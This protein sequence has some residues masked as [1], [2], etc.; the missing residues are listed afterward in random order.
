MTLTGFWVMLSWPS[1]YQTHACRPITRNLGGGA[2]RRSMGDWWWSKV[3]AKGRERGSS[4]EQKQQRRVVMKETKQSGCHTA[5]PSLLISAA[6]F[7]RPGKAVQLAFHSFPV[8]GYAVVPSHPGPWPE[9]G[10]C[11]WGWLPVLCHITSAR[12]VCLQWGQS[13]HLTGPLAQ[14][15]VLSSS[16]SQLGDI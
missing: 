16:F 1:A 8:N 2:F 7:S 3:V 11:D 4:E 13:Q 6:S 14:L 10:P 9:P 15:Y 12:M 5:S